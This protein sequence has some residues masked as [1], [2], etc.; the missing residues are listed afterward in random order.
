M[1]TAAAYGSLSFEQQIQFFQ[2][3][4]PSIDYQGIRGAAHDRAFIS[5]GAHRIDLV[6]DLFMVI[7]RAIREGMTLQEFQPDYEAVLDHY[8]W[9]P[10]GGRNWRA[11][12]IYH[13]NLRTSYAAGR[14]AQ[15][16]EVKDRRPYWGYQHSDAVLHP[17]E[18]HLAWDNLVIHAD[19]PWWLSHYPPNGWGC[20]CTVIAYNLR[21]LKRMGKNGPDKAPAI[22][23]RKITFKGAEIKV[24]EGID[25]GW[26]YAP[27]GSDIEQ[28]IQR[29][30]EKA[31]GLPEEL[32]ESLTAELIENLDSGN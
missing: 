27:G 24:P 29:I 6:R 22:K 8:G 15:L 21:D 32:A 16:L 30:L 2:G 9:E 14:Y 4:F 20:Q 3:K 19:D 23:L 10:N 11:S 26:D 18:Q 31:E 12:V 17:R 5:A 1:A 13:T 25:P 28:Q 7:A